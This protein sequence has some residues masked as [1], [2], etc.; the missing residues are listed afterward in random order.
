M[1]VNKVEYYGETLMDTTGTTVSEET[2]ME[3]ETAIN[4]AGEQITGNLKPVKYTAQNPTAAEQ[5]QAR[6]NIDALGTGDLPEAINT[7]LAQAKES[8]QFDGADGDDG[9]PGADGVGIQSI[10]QITASNEDGGSNVWRATLTNNAT[11]DFTVKN[12]S[13]GKQGDVGKTA[14]EYAKDG[15]YKGTEEDFMDLVNTI[16]SKADN[17]HGHTWDEVGLIHYEGGSDTIA[18]DGVIYDA[19]RKVCD[20]APTLSEVQR[21]GRISYYSNGEL[22]TANFLEGYFSILSRSESVI[23]AYDG[24]PFVVIALADRITYNGNRFTRGTHFCQDSYFCV[25]SLTINNYAGFPYDVA[26]KIPSERLP[27]D[28]GSVKTVNNVAPDENGNISI[29]VGG[30]GGGSTECTWDDLAL[31]DTVK[32]LT[33]TSDDV[34]YGGYHKVSDETPTLEQLRKGGTISFNEGGNGITTMNYP[35]GTMAVM[36]ATKGAVIAFNGLPLAVVA[37]EDGMTY[38]GNTFEKGISFAQDD[39]VITHSLTIKDYPT[40]GINPIPVEY[41]PESHQFGETT[42]YGDTITWD[43][44]MTGRAYVEME[45]PIDDEGNTVPAYFVKVSDAVPTFEE[46]QSGGTIT[47]YMGGGS[48][49][50]EFGE[51]KDLYYLDM[52][53]IMLDETMQQLPIIAKEDNVDVM[54]MFTLPQKGVYILSVPA[55]ELYIGSFTINNYTGFESV[56]INTIDT[57]YLGSFDDIHRTYFY[58][59]E[60][61]GDAYQLYVDKDE[62]ILATYQDIENAYK[63]GQIVIVSSLIHYIPVTINLTPPVGA[64]ICV[65]DDS[66]ANSP[67]GTAEYRRYKVGSAD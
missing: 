25:H 28:I 21:G 35:E 58:E 57:K 61:N 24:Y 33:I 26:Q 8:G 4:A 53:N 30:G 41:M 63:K 20:N 46:L 16:D 27:E 2:L 65:L 54:E 1:E 6:K 67:I 62:T 64:T 19:Y 45:L 23:I 29:E 34:N 7:A 59:G 44:D 9:D 11:A 39:I 47:A 43:G 12:G 13:K 49:P 10:K 36:S 42:T 55:A 37:F 56:E 50:M 17:K 51:D 22:V 3:G 40:V 32:D 48:A 14:Y 31:Y 5:A 66:A 60:V 38:M 18:S 15:G 52:G